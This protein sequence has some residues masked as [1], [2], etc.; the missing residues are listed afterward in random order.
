MENVRKHRDIKLVI[1]DKKISQ[2][3]SELN[4]HTRKYFSEDLLP[5]KVK[6]IKAKMNKLVYFGAWIL[7]NRKTFLYEFWYNYIKPKYKKNEKLCY[8][9]VDSFIIHIK[10]EN[11]YKDIVHDVEKWLDTSI[12]E[13]DTPLLRGMNKKVIGLIRDER[14]GKIMI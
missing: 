1:T 6:K 14:R 8:M 13:V 11:F 2:L 12:N 10:T 4:Y 5:I 7:E 3:V 9:D